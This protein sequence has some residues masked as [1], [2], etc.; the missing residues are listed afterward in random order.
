M[1]NKQGTGLDNFVSR[2]DPQFHEIDLAADS[3][4]GILF[5][6]MRHDKSLFVTE[7]MLREAL[8]L[9][10]EIRTH[11][12]TLTDLY[13]RPLRYHAYA[14]RREGVFNLGG[15]LNAIPEIIASQQR[16]KLEA[17]AYLCIQAI[18]NTIVTY[19]LPVITV[20]LIDGDALGGGFEFVLANSLAIARNN[21]SFGFPEA[22]FNMFPGMGAYNLLSRRIGITK[23]EEFLLSGR[24]LKTEDVANMGLID[25]A[26]NTSTTQA[27]YYFIRDRDHQHNFRHSLIKARN[28]CHSVYWQDLTRIAD[29]WVDTALRLGD[30][31]LKKMRRFAGLQSLTIQGGNRD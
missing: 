3:E 18:Y 27:L 12:E 4:Y 21:Q 26:T 8:T 2:L 25:I 7:Q 15:D 19:E 20:A 24:M 11:Y 22:L 9:H 31:E 16:E 1:E 6:Y 23:T 13:N 10:E 29:L 17:Y 30:E 28:I 5:T 14:S